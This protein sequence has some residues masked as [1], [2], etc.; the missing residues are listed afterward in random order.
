MDNYKTQD[1]IQPIIDFVY[2]CPFLDEYFIDLGDMGTQKF[3]SEIAPASCIDYVGS[4]S[5][6][7]SVDSLCNWKE[8]KQRNYQLFLLRQSNDDV[9]RKEAHNFISNFEDWVSYCQ[10]FGLTP[11]ISG[12]PK[13]LMW[14]SNGMYF[15]EWADEHGNM[16]GT[17][18]YMIQLHIKYTKQY[19]R[20]V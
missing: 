3:T 19:E 17:S 16:S 7:Y 20:G 6:T 13:E 14:A 11:K 12:D 4:I 8:E 10:V 5:P 2:Q 9:Y 15:N 1:I 18:V